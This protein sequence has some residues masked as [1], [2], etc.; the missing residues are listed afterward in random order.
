MRICSKCHIE[1]ELT[2]F[3]KG[4]GNTLGYNTICKLCK[5]KYMVEYYR[6]NHERIITRM[7][8]YNKIRRTHGLRQST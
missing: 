8:V 5:S 1:K 4:I 3:H 2:D 7:M 6:K